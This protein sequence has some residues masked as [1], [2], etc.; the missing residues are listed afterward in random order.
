MID[1]LVVA[2]IP[3]YREGMARALGHGRRVHVL[4]TA[5][6]SQEALSRVRDLKPEVILV[7]VAMNDG[8]D[9]V[10]A[11]GEATPEAKVVALAVSDTEADVIACA[12]AGVWGYV[13][14][15]GTLDDLEAVVESVARG[16]SL[17]SPRIAASL[18]R[19]VG[20]LAAELR[21]PPPVTSL[22]ARE[23][24][25]AALL[26]QGLSN[27]EIAQR[28]SIAV[29]TVKNHV[30]S[31]LDKLHVNRRTEAAARLK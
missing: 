16:E 8:F 18:L 21:G 25:V 28:L 26:D 13:P 29:P 22:T 2:D 12:E 3:L 4:G 23:L 30:H 15:D 5:T 19:R 14:R 27:K 20:A 31:I 6:S 17:C 10:R 11:I 1:V 24:E 7:D 9:T